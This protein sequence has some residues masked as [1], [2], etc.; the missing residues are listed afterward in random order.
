MAYREEVEF[1][2][3]SSPPLIEQT[4]NEYQRLRRLMSSCD[5][6]FRKAGRV[7][8]ESEH[9]ERYTKRLREA[10]DLAEHLSA[11]FKRVGDALDAYG[12]AVETARGHYESGQTTESRLSE[13][14]SR[15]A[16]AVTQ[17]AKAAEPLRQWEDVRGTT[18]FFD[19]VAEIGV[20][21]DAIREEAEHYY[22]ATKGHFGD[23]KRVEAEAREE[24]LHEVRAAYRSLPD[25]RGGGFADATQ[26]LGGV[27]AL[28]R[29]TRDAADD[30]YAQ[31]RGTG[32]K[33]DTIPKVGP[34]VVVSPALMRINEKT[35]GKDAEGNYI[36]VYSNDD[37]DR[38]EYISKNK[39]LL[40]AAAADSGLP[41]EMVAGIAWKEVEGQPSWTDEVLP[42]IR[43]V[44]PGTTDPDLTSMGPMSVQVRRAA[45]V[46]GY[47]PQNL[48]DL[49]REQVVDAVKD[50]AKNIYIA[51]E[52]LAQLKAESEFANV[53]PEQM[54]PEQMQELAAR[55]NG[56][57][58]YENEQAQNY[59]RDFDSHREEAK[60]ALGR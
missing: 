3:L 37:D 48:T 4:A 54:T 10:T 55:Y 42:V 21:V 19:W 12:K 32:A 58:Y 7:E 23:A 9:R 5:E 38:R 29:E 46:L 14:I 52:Y 17:T 35:A 50:P 2:E 16:E 57:P 13:V 53:P 15:E 51:S 43:D 41:P 24:C 49:Q 11:A 33:V 39:E 8:W 36:W 25:F 1:L 28:R 59:G 31:L 27:D 26:L 45:E 18:G 47:D 34:D 20:D 44:V 22:N 60:R 6:D 40:T 56:G 30:P